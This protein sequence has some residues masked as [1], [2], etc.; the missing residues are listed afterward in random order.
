L[1]FLSLH[2][3]LPILLVSVFP[4]A[5]T[6]PMR[7]P[8]AARARLKQRLGRLAAHLLLLVSIGIIAFPVYSV[9]VLSTRSMEE[10]VV[11][12]TILRPSTHLVA[13]YITAW[14]QAGKIG[15]AHV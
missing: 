14:S 10:V 5:A 2:A 15:R 13:N 3:A 12:P 7:Q 11:R 6:R 8:P 9:F 1:D 4:R